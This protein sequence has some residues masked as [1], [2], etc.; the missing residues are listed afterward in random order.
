MKNQYETLGLQEGASQEAIQEAF[1]RLSKEL[2]PANNENQ[3][4]FI[5]EYEKVQEAYKVLRNSSILSATSQFTGISNS[6]I[7]KSTFKN[8][9]P[10]NQ[11]K[12][13]LKRHKKLIY[14]LI[15]M[16]LVTMIPIALFYQDKPYDTDVY[17]SNEES[18]KEVINEDVIK[19]NFDKVY[20][21]NGPKSAVYHKSNNCNGLYRC[22]KEVAYVDKEKA[23][24]IGRRPCKLEF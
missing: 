3:E 11:L 8:N 15:S 12:S 1:E 14:L 24:Q 9:N 18:K 5:E 4:F 21:C 17:L 2:N 19:S 22:S 23:I 7:G 20:I 13:K 6:S 10:K 16:V